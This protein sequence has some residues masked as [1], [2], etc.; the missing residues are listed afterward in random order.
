MSKWHRIGKI[1]ITH[2]LIDQAIQDT[3]GESI[4][5]FADIFH[6]IGF[7]PIKIETLSP[8]I[9]E[10][11][12]YSSNFNLIEYS[13]EIPEYVVTLTTKVNMN[14]FEQ[15]LYARVDIVVNEE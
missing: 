8:N 15:K 6:Q 7:V 10:Y 14:S 12:G 1:K 5:K 9:Y 13:D 2:E 11:T 3:S 4:D